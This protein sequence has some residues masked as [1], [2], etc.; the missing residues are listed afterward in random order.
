MISMEKPRK[1]EFDTISSF[2]MRMN[3]STFAILKLN[4]GLSPGGAGG[5]SAPPVENSKHFFGQNLGKIRA[6]IAVSNV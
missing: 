4:T 3:F 1:L 6:K 5:A 2:C